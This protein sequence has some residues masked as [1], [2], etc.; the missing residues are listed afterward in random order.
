MKNRASEKAE[1]LPE[2][3]FVFFSVASAMFFKKSL[4]FDTDAVVSTAVVYEVLFSA[5]FQ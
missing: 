1:C 3:A 5:R 4:S 2:H